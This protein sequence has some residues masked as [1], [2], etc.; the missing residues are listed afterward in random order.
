MPIRPRATISGPRVYLRPPRNSDVSAFLAAARASR[1]LHGP[2]TRPPDTAARYA[3]F[4][5]RYAPRGAPTT[6]AG[7]L[8]CRREDNALVGVFNLSEIVRG[9]FCSAYLGYFGFAPYARRGY[10]TEGMAL[11]LDVA[12]RTLRLHRVEVNIQPTNVRSLRLARRI[13]LAREGFSRRYVKI[14]GRWRDHV[15]FA[16]LAEDWRALRRKHR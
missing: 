4:V 5:E 6:H 7:Y 8:V 14:G 10:M 2:W 3:A 15:R 1:S 11:V 16:M 9:A 13:G 12:F